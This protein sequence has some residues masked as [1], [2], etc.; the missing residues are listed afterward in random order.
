M[1][2]IARNRKN[3]FIILPSHKI[4]VLKISRLIGNSVTL[5]KF[6]LG[7]VRPNWAHQMY[8]VDCP[9]PPLPLGT[10]QRDLTGVET[11][12]KQSVLLS[13][14]VGKFSF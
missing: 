3:G 4:T 12:L 5:S 7:G 14:S 8:R 10:V 13:Y 1:K 2:C 11:R 9:Y 6:W